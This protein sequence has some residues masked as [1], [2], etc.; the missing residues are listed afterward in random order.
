VEEGKILDIAPFCVKSLIFLGLKFSCVDLPSAQ[1]ERLIAIVEFFGGSF[2]QDKTEATHII[3]ANTFENDKYHSYEWVNDCVRNRQ[4]VANRRLLSK[5]IIYITGFDPVDRDLKD[6]AKQFGATVSPSYN[7]TITHLVVPFAHGKAYDK[8][9]QDK[10]KIVSGHYI[11]SCIRHNKVLNEKDDP[12]YTPPPAGG[13]GEFKNKTISIS[14]FTGTEKLDLQYIITACGA[15]WQAGLSSDTSV[16]IVDDSESEKYKAAQQWGVKIHK[17]I[18]LKECLKEWKWVNKPYIWLSNTVTTETTNENLKALGAIIMEKYTSHVTHIVVGKVSKTEKV[19]CA[20]AGGKYLMGHEWI[21]A[22]IGQKRFVP[23]EDY[24][25][26]GKKNPDPIGDVVKKWRKKAQK[27][28]RAFCKWVVIARFAKE[29]WKTVL[30]AGGA[31]IVQEFD[32]TV[33]DDE[34]KVVV[35]EESEENMTEIKNMKL[36]KDVSVIKSIFLADYLT[37]LEDVKMDRYL[38]K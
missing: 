2:T 30:T 12:M 5:M 37:T 4:L 1:V 26:G 14:G 28:E 27:G 7:K 32:K 25:V 11:D 8:A 16:L 35:T 13:I 22:C 10:K 9:V 17:A 36:D 33:D 20:L 19:L 38:I 34:K 6:F 3:C 29:N 31:K 15:E 23:E 21:D 24:E 18:W